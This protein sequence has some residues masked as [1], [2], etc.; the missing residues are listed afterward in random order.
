MICAQF[1]QKYPNG[2][3]ISACLIPF[4]FATLKKVNF[5]NFLSLKFNIKL[6]NLQVK[7]DV[8]PALKKLTKM[9]SSTAHPAKDFTTCII[10]L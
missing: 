10:F 9:Y 4:H 7:Q 2:Y 5:L 8:A 3:A 1:Y 6:L